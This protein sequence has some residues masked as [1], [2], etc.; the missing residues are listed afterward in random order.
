M[1]TKEIIEQIKNDEVEASMILCLNDDGDRVYLHH[2]PDEIGALEFLEIMAA[3]LR[4]DIL[5]RVVK[6]SMN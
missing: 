6:R 4:A 3:G 1:S 5:E 2:F